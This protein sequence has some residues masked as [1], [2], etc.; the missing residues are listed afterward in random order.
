MPVCF[1]YVAGRFRT[2]KGLV[3]DG[4]PSLSPYNGHFGGLPIPLTATTILYKKKNY[5]SNLFDIINIVLMLK[6][7]FSEIQID[8]DNGLFF[9]EYES[10][11]PGVLDLRTESEILA[12]KLYQ[13]NSKIILGLSSGLDSQIILHSF[14]SQNLKIKCAFMH[15]PGLN[16]VEYEQVRILEKK[17][18]LDLII[19]Q[20]NPNECKEEL[21]AEFEKTKIPPYQLLHKK[22][23]SKLPKDYDFIQG[24]DGPDFYRR[25]DK[26]YI[27]QTANSYVNS[28][29][30]ALKMLERSGRIINWERHSNILLSI[31]VDDTVKN[32]LCAYDVFINNQ[33]VYNDG[34]EIPIIDQWDL[35]IKPFIY[36]KCWKNELT[37]FPK[38]QGC[39]GLEWVM[40]GKWHKYREN[41]VIIPYDE[42]VA[43]LLSTGSTKR[44]TE[45]F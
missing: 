23:L 19:I 44:Y 20:I 33:L 9:V 4:A 29:S 39:E 13:Q 41:L 21:L 1:F 38:Y 22:F 3:Y 25:N 45:L 16:E 2:Y 10:Y 34:S 7:H 12:K 32:F 35:Y 17:Y 36:A 11:G 30:R 26:W 31:L 14:Y 15:L 8:F 42:I 28:R 24:I 6:N 43:H 37:Y 5:K 40:K 27:L 18:G